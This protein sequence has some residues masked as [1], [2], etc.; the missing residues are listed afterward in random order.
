MGWRYRA[1]K[2]ACMNSEWLTTWCDRPVYS[3]IVC[4]DVLLALSRRTADWWV[5]GVNSCSNL[6]SQH[7]VSPLQFPDASLQRDIRRM[8]WVSDQIFDSNQTPVDCRQNTRAK[9]NVSTLSAVFFGRPHAVT[10]WR[11]QRARRCSP[12]THSAWEVTS[13]ERA[14]LLYCR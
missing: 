5:E 12:Q 3:W 14:A 4:S 6:Y 10:V 9:D 13:R 11:T 1:S 2:K 8:R 7:A